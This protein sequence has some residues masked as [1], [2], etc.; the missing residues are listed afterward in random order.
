MQQDKWSK[1]KW[2][3][4]ELATQALYESHVNNTRNASD[5]ALNGAKFAAY[6]KVLKYMQDAELQEQKELVMV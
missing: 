3:V 2:V 5:A 4:E 1:T 6:N